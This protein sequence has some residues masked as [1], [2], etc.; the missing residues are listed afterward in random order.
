MYA[1]QQSR[2][3]LAQART[4]QRYV[5][6]GVVIAVCV[7]RLIDYIIF[8]VSHSQVMMNDTED[9]VNDAG[10]QYSTVG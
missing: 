4:N 2:D 5:K 8:K 3:R 6:Y 9:G 7:C 10:L 1:L